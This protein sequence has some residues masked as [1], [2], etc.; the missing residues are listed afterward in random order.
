M[1]GI[2]PRAPRPG[3]R[4]R[5]VLG[6]VAIAGVVVIAAR[7]GEAREFVRLLRGMR[8][9]WLLAATLLQAA[10]YACDA[11]IWEH[12]LSRAGSHQ[13]FRRLFGLSV[14]KVFISQAVP[15]GGVSGD[16]MVV[17]SL[18]KYGVPLD[19]SMTALVIGLFG[20]YA[21]FA[22]CSLAAIA[23]FYASGVGTGPIRAIGIPFSLVIVALPALLAWLVWSGQASHRGRWSRLPGLARILDAFGRAR[24]DVLRQRDLLAQSMGLQI[25]TFL[26]D[27]GTL[28]VML[29]AFGHVAPVPGVFAAF[30]V[31]SAAELVGPVPGGFGTFEG[32]CIIGLRAFGVPIETALLATLMVRGFTFWLPMIPGFLIARWAVAPAKN[33]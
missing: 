20:F 25:A 14:G 24:L 21:A 3:D 33:Q 6:A 22:T 4:V 18:A 8:P 15:S 12:V 31:A 2:E 11:G 5:W 13:P 1:G 23:V 26:F 29:A 30:I 16:V 28:L 27:A 7:G 17:R 32:G 10:T 19:A 9:E